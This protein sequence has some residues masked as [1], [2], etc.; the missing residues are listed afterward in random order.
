MPA[1]LVS[2]RALA[3][4]FETASSFSSSCSSCRRGF[5]DCSVG[6]TNQVINKSPCVA[7]RRQSSRWVTI[8]DCNAAA[9]HSI[10]VPKAI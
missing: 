7:M 6:P 5:I 1:D 10:S 3:P 9:L 8:D 2:R 4:G